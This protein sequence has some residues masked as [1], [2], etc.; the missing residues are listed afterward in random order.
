MSSPSYPPL[1]NCYSCDLQV[2]WSDQDL[3]GHVNNARI[4]TLLEEARVQAGKIWTGSFPDGASPRVVRT[5]NV[6]FLRAVNYEMPVKAAVW[7]SKIGNSSYTVCH[8]LLQKGESC[9][10]GETV[11][12]VLDGN[13][14]Q[15]ARISDEIRTGLEKF[16]VPTP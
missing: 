6:Q 2:R 1:D 12:V 9:V 11:I 15:P 5:L 3:N 4:V 13:T 16:H 10:Y 8:E 14:K 7:I